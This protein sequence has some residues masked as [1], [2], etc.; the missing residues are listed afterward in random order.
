MWDLLGKFCK[1][2]VYELL[3]GLYRDEVE[4]AA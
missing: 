1:Q 3:G 4:L 2:P